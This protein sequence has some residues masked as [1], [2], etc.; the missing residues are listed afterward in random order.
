MIDV[1]SKFE[2]DIRLRNFSPGT[3]KNYRG[4][5]RRYLGFL[6]SVSLE[7][8]TEADIRRYLVFLREE[9]HIAPSTI[10]VYH[11]AVIFLY[12]VTCNR[13]LN[14]KQVPR[15]KLAKELPALLSRQELTVLMAAP[16]S[17][18]HRVILSL[19]YGSGLRA[20]EACRLRVQD[21]D[22]EKMRI[23]VR[24]GKGR[25]DRYTVLSKTSL[26]LL[27][28]YWRAYR[29]NHPEGWMFIGNK[30]KGH[31]SRAVCARALKVACKKAGVD[32]Q[33]YN[34]HTL[35]HC[36]STYMLEDGTSLLVLKELL[37]HRSLSSTTV[38]L[39][40]VNVSEGLACPIDS[41]GAL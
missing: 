6:G 13:Q 18:R 2:E 14:R 11:A 41:V 22:S 12:E 16:S 33:K 32:P 21:I 10:N 34:Y 3:L 31:L 5:I 4:A 8:T 38:Y 23:F 9:C 24:A 7:S 36:F 35:R 26:S 28:E 27:R 37:G 30:G 29:P 17:L 1:L 19:G 15:C 40:L 39:H 20:S 25:K